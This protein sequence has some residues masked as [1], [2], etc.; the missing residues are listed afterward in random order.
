MAYSLSEPPIPMFFSECSGKVC[1]KQDTLRGKICLLAVRSGLCDR[2]GLMPILRSHPFVRSKDHPSA[3]TC[4]HVWAHAR[5]GGQGWPSLRPRHALTVS[6]PLLDGR[7]HGGGSRLNGTAG[8]IS[9]RD[10]DLMQLALGLIP[11]W[12]VK[13]CAFD[14]AKRRLDIEIDFTRGGRFPCPQC[15]KADCP[16]H[17]TAMQSSIAGTIGP[18]DRASSR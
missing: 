15:G 6:R 4:R 2:R 14:A 5:S 8:D 18:S 10:T 13:A 17:D 11:P 1:A 7:E 3:P 12:M 16:V 9:M